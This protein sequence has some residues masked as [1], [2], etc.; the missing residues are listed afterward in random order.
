MRLTLI[1]CCSSANHDHCFS[2]NQNKS[3]LT[4]VY[5]LESTC[6][7]YESQIILHRRLACSTYGLDFHIEHTAQSSQQS[8]HSSVVRET[9]EHLNG[10]EIITMESSFFGFKGFLSFL[11]FFYLL[12]EKH[13]YYKLQITLIANHVSLQSRYYEY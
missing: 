6:T 7:V 10:L 5:T 4:Q 8:F 9:R 12:K 2:T 13:N 3:S 11:C 1:D